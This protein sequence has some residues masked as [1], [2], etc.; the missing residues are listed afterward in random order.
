MSVD[1]LFA[2]H[3]T[4]RRARGLNLSGVDLTGAELRG[5]R[6][7]G[8]DLADAILNEA[9]LGQIR[10]TNCVLRNVQ[11]TLAD[12]ADAT[13]RMCDL[14]GARG[15]GARLHRVRIENCSATGI[16]LQRAS[17]REASLID[18]DLS[19]ANL[20]EA[21]LEG[22]RASGVCLRGAD[23]TGAN[24]RGVDL[25]DA[26]LRGADLTDAD[27]SGAQLSGADLRGTIG[28]LQQDPPPAKPILPP[29]L[30][31][32]G[33]VVAP[34]VTDVLSQLA[35]GR[36][37]SPEAQ[38]KWADTLR[39]DPLF[40]ELDVANV[41][42]SKPIQQTVATVMAAVADDPDILAKAFG[43]LQSDT[44]PPEVAALMSRL[45]EAFEI[46][47]DNTAEELLTQ[48]TGRERASDG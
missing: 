48:M 35:Q 14:S 23:L 28:G 18:S 39:D 15:E 11:F 40:A 45:A 33:R 46:S 30:Q 43:A 20:R 3:T 24:L 44:P 31:P 21:N 25:T 9:D 12:L 41:P 38:Q 10:V 16:D 27:L 47:G 1:A 32:L 26:D 17:L 42:P 6:A 8:L 37:M 2:A 13:L 29:D 22:A 7:D 4:K 36:R 19:R 34:M 5:L